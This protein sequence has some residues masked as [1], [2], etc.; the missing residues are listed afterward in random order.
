VTAGSAVTSAREETRSSHLGP[1]PLNVFAA[2]SGV[3]WPHDPFA[4]AKSWGA[5]RGGQSILARIIK[6]IVVGVV[7]I[8]Q[9]IRRSKA[10]RGTHAAQEQA[11]SAWCSVGRN[12]RSERTRQFHLLGFNRR[13]TPVACAKN[14][15]ERGSGDAAARQRRGG[16]LQRSYVL[17]KFDFRLMQKCCRLGLETA[18]PLPATPEFALRT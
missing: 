3:L 18:Q 1:P 13:G 11:R 4:E 8:G 6:P 5:E 17:Q 7:C 2:L 15:Q 10:K 16:N 9:G 12:H 14:N